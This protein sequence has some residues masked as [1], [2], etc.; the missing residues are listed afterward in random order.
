MAASP[1]LS[2][3]TESTFLILLSLAPEPRHGYAIMQDV[4]SLSE[5]RVNLSTGTLYTALKRLLDDGWIE[6]VAEE[7]APRGRKSYRLTAIGR[8]ILDAE[9]DRMATLAA[10][11]RRR[12][13]GAP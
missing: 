7:T 1:S 6:P 8:T 11:A 4:A 9:T 13:A 10:V 2:P 3:L 12:L 5:G